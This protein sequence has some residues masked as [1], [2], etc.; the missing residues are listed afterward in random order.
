MGILDRIEARRRGQE[1]AYPVGAAVVE[2]FDTAFGHRDETYSPEEYGDYLVTSNEVFSA[3][4]LRARLVSSVPLRVYRGRDAD[5]RELPNSPAAQLLGY[6]NPHWTQARLAR[7]DELSACLW[8]Q[9]VWAVER[10]PSGV[11]QEIWW[12]KPSRVLPVPD[13]NRYLAGYRYESNVD[14]QVIEFA[15]NEIVWHRYPNPLDEFSALS[16]VAAAR[17]PADTGSAMMKANRN[18][19]KQGLQIAG[20]VVPKSHGQGHTAVQFTRDQA[21]QLQD[22][23]ERRFAGAD[24]AH[25]WAVLRYEAEFKPVN[26]SP[27]DAEFINGLGLSL[28]QVCN[29]YGI[30]APLLNDLEHATLANIREFQKGLWEHA[31]VPDLNLRAQEIE[32]QFLPMFGRSRG[33]TVPDHIEP[34]FSGVAALQESQSEVWDRER[35]A[36]EV[37]ALTVNEWRKKRGMP[38]VRWGDVW[39]APVNKA[40]VKDEASLPASAQD[41]PGGKP[42]AE[43]DA[44]VQQSVRE[45]DQVLAAL[46]TDL[47]SVNGYGGHS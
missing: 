38:P 21:E 15:A 8:G 18:L 40:A 44:P 43:N 17:L 47:H 4:M 2:P 10:D 28:R 29:A 9:S 3:A 20:M 34:D 13:E 35:Q 7:M 41:N 12:L 23:L 16:P 25:R 6:V 31:L 36:I 22:S 5:K 37:G 11:P 26:I 30:P 27:K 33:R 32:E 39:W 24:K 45:W 1:L 46:E 14:G 19:H 42:A